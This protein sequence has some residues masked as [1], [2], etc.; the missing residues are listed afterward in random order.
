[1]SDPEQYE[2]QAAVDEQHEQQGVLPPAEDFYERM[3]QLWNG[4]IPLYMTFWGYYFGVCMVASVLAR[5]LSPIA[6]FISLAALL[7]TVFMLRPLIMAAKNYEG[8]AHWAYATYAMVALS[9]YVMVTG[10]F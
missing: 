3:E 7:W 2:E 8:P 10:L 5:I 9:V 4:E 6:G 1:M